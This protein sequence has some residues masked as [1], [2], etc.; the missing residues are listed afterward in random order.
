MALPG[1][2]W[3]VSS[4]CRVEVFKGNGTEVPC[5]VADRNTVVIEWLAAI[6]DVLISECDDD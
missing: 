6:L 5:E 2:E 3:V 1:W 4:E